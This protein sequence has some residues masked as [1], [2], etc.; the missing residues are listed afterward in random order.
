MNDY[1]TSWTLN[2]TEVLLQDNGRD[3]ANGVPL[4]DAM[5]K[6]PLDYLDVNN[7][8]APTGVGSLVDW[9]QSLFA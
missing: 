7:I 4:L 3:Q 8:P 1:A 5:I 9:I 6:V 2:G